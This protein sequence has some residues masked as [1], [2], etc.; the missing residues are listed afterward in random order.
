MIRIRT[1]SKK[2]G[3]RLVELHGIVHG[4]HAEQR[5]DLFFAEP[6]PMRLRAFFDDALDDVSVHVLV[7]EGALG[8]PLAGYAV[9]QVAGREDSAQVRGH[10][11]VTL[12]QLAVDPGASRSGVGTAL[13]EAVREIGREAGCVRLITNVW[14]FNTPARSFYE[15]SGLVPT[16]QRLEQTL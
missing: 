8:A 7:A 6:D 13:L 14:C 2:D 16:T 1:A 5:P 9:A 11:A 12:R 10:S 3:Q 4:L 15:A